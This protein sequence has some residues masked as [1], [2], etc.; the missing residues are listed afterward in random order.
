MLVRLFTEHPA[1]VGENYL[2]HM[3]SAGSFT[4]NLILAGA[5][6]AVHALFPF[7][8]EKTASSIISTLYDRMVI[9]R[10]RRTMPVLGETPTP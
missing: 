9:N 10:D 4:G 5:A 2:E 3:N 7:L 6:C 8:F 1:S